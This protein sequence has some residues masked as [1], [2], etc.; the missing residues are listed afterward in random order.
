MGYKIINRKGDVRV[1]DDFSDIGIKV[2]QIWYSVRKLIENHYYIIDKAGESVLL[3][4][5]HAQEIVYKEVCERL[6]KRK[7]CAFVI[8]KARQHGITT[9]IEA[10][11]HVL[12]MFRKNQNCVI[13]A[14]T[15]ENANKIFMKMD[16]FQQHLK[17]QN[18]ARE[19]QSK[20][21]NQM[22]TKEDPSSIRVAP[23]TMDA[24]RGTTVNF[25]EGSEVAFWDNQD[26]VLAAVLAAVPTVEINPVGFI[27]LESTANGFNAFKEIWDEANS[28]PKDKSI[29]V[30]IF[31]P[32][33]INED[34]RLEEPL[35]ERSLTAFEKEKMV[36]HGLD[37]YQMA[38]WR[39]KF[40]EY[41]RNRTLTLQEYP[42]DPSDAFASTGYGVFDTMLL[43]KR[44]E[45]LRDLP[46]LVGFMKHEI[47]PIGGDIDRL[48]MKNI[49][50]RESEIGILK[51][52]E[53]PIEGVPYVLGVDMAVGLG[54]DN[55]AVFVYRNDTKKQV[56]SMTANNLP[57]D[58]FS[59][60]VAALAYWYNNAL[61]APE[62][63]YGTTLIRILKK[64]DYENIYQREVDDTSNME[65]FIQNLGIKT[66]QKNKP[67][68][69][70]NF[71]A[72]CEDDIE[73]YSNLMDY[74]LLTEMTSF[75]YDYGKGV[76][77]G[78]SIKIKGAGKN[79]D[80]RVMAAILAYAGSEQQTT[81]VKTKEDKKSG[82]DQFMKWLYQEDSDN[83]SGGFSTFYL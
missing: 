33:Y 57:A 34:Y 21:G 8:L 73:P 5:N 76:N 44:K 32:W 82:K 74:Q 63:N 38:F 47:I 68:M 6:Y 58:T 18:L 61:I 70:D 60:D 75:V 14:N 7:R 69:V 79:H 29:Y 12:T 64:L 66:T 13:I 52:F 11:G 15:N 37:L 59:Y 80:D 51:V 19:L 67:A 1:K 72:I 43:E 30:P 81:I 40:V 28:V 24:V 55:S 4:L 17:D 3:K 31:L 26:D 25:F 78:Q 22:V 10:L 36:K 27:F 65:G 39:S 42:F 46:Y 83:D 62:V 50:F 49:E 48:V 16:Y 9:L 54:N 45:K 41:K 71:R 20:T 23:A 77:A 35:D 56:A 53:K 2:G